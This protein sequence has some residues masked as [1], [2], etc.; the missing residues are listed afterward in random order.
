[1]L[2][3][4]M[5]GQHFLRCPGKIRLLPVNSISPTEIGDMGLRRYTGAA[6]ENNAVMAR[7]HILQSV[8]VSHD[9]LLPAGWQNSQG[10]FFILSFL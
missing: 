3:I 8:Q 5:M 7:Y 2:L 1:M 10:I 6:K 9:G 4:K